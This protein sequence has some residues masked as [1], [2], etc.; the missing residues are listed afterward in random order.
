[1]P[2]EFCSKAYFFQASGSLT[3][4]KSQTQHP[5][6]KSPS[7][8]TCA[9]DFYVLKKS[10]DLS[11]VWTREPWIS[12]RARYL[13]TTEADLWSMISYIKGGKQTKGI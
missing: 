12:R 6:L 4:L 7:W 3:S 13:E 5:Q 1:M 8:R 10:I 2:I 11:R 9:Q